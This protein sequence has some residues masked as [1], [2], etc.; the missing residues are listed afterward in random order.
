MQGYRISKKI[1]SNES[2]L[3]DQIRDEFE[4]HRVVMQDP[5]YRGEI[6][7]ID[8]KT[9]YK[10]YKLV[11]IINNSRIQVL[12]NF[13][14]PEFKQSFKFSKDLKLMI[15]LSTYEIYQRC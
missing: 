2:K 5:S 12:M 13:L 9:G 8:R 10:L 11:E 6:L 15:D 14:I 7:E 3:A 1:L 4:T